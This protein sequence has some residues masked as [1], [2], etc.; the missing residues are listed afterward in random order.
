MV[1]VGVCVTCTL[2]CSSLL[3]WNLSIA[4]TLGLVFFGHHRQVAALSSLVPTP[5]PPPVFHRF[6]YDMVGEGRGDLVTCDAI[7]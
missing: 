6:Q 3:Q 4:V 7:K 1:Y 5:F 2:I